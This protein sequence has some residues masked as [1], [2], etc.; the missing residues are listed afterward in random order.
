VKGSRINLDLANL[1]WKYYVRNNR[2]YNAA[3]TLTEIAN[4]STYQLDL[5]KRVEY[6]TLANAQAKGILPSEMDGSQYTR[7]L[8]DRLDVAKIQLDIFAALEQKPDKEQV[9]AQ[10][11]SQLYD[12]TFLY[13]LTEKERLYTLTLEILHVSRHYEQKL[14]SSIWDNIISDTVKPKRGEAISTLRSVIA[15][16]GAKFGK[17][18][19]AFPLDMVISKLEVTS[20]QLADIQTDHGWITKVMRN[21]EIPYEMIFD[22]THSLF[23]Q[24]N[25][26]WNQQTGLIFLLRDIYQLI[27]N[28]FAFAISPNTDLMDHKKFPANMIDDAINKY[29][30]ALKTTEASDLVSQFQTLQKQ[31]RKKF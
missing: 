31:L 9:L 8:Q 29:L 16:L 10:L 2:R 17:S 27:S 14:L 5:R 15:Q 3:Q 18:G 26:P 23:E 30:M 22:A 28:W 11:S 24:G 13:R 1:L 6:L 4:S 21:N 12:I 19:D 25:P 7:E 20:F